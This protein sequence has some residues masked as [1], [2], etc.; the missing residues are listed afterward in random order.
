MKRYD[1]NG[2]DATELPGLW[3]ED[4]RICNEP[5]HPDAD[6]EHCASYWERMIGEGLWDYQRG[7][8]T[9]AGWSDILRHA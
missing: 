5:C 4:D 8:W 1:T 3:S 2:R 6:C 9:D 7:R